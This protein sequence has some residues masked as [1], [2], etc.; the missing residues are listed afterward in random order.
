MHVHSKSERRQVY[1]SVA[2]VLLLL[3]AYALGRSLSALAQVPSPFDNPPPRQHFLSG[4]E[5]SEAVLHD[6]LATLRQ[7][8]DRLARIERATLDAARALQSRDSRDV[9]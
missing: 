8:D 5:R 2:L 1:R 9:R 4:S 6:I 3:G 7:M